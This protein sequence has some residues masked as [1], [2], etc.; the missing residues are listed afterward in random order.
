MAN[1][2]NDNLENR[3]SDL[4]KGEV[5][6]GAIGFLYGTIT[7]ITAYTLPE[8]SNNLTLLDFILHSHEHP[9]F[10]LDIGFNTV[11]GAVA[12]YHLAKQ[13]DYIKNKANEVYTKVEKFKDE[14][15]KKI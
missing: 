11:V 4:T 3:T 7:T 1:K 6:G 15:T 9:A 14:A 10:L 5:V 8:P 13:L 2:K 12:G